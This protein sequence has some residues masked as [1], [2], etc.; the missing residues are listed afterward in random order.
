MRFKEI[1]G[2]IFFI[3]GLN[4]VHRMFYN[5]LT[6]TRKEG[7]EDENKKDETPPLLCDVMCF[8]IKQYSLC[9]KCYGNGDRQQT[10]YP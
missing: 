10:E 9:R 3:S 2:D 1:D 5:G 7:S 8:Y 6:Q 4:R